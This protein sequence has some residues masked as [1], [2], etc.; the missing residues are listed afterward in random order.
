ME[1]APRSA[2]G[3]LRSIGVRSAIGSS[4]W[5]ADLRPRFRGVHLSPEKA[6]VARGDRKV[7][8]L[9]NQHLQGEYH[10]DH[11]TAFHRADLARL[12]PARALGLRAAGGCAEIAG[13]DPANRTGDGAGVVSARQ[14]PSGGTWSTDHLRERSIR[15]AE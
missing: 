14:G 13:A 3:R 9:L 11:E 15:S 1:P 12:L 8:T 4:G 2:L 7:A 6:I 5:I 10:A